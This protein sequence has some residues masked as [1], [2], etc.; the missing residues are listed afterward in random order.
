MRSGV[1]SREIRSSREIPFLEC[2]ACLTPC[3]SQVED[4]ASPVA[5]ARTATAAL[6][7]YPTALAEQ[8][9]LSI[10]ADEPV[11]EVVGLGVEA[12]GDAAAATGDAATFAS[13]SPGGRC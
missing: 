7:Q 5:P 9:S 4:A 10:A 3:A 2:G 6:L 11:G 8:L 13:L 1:P 12:A